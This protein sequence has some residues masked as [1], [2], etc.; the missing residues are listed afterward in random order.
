[1]N[2][3]KYGYPYPP[4]GVYQGPPPVMAP[5]QYYAPHAAA[6]ATASRLSGGMSCSCLLLL[7]LG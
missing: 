7:P 3:P 5:P 6:A 1:M 4:Q 2:E